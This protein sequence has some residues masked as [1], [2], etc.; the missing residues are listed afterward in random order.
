M[1]HGFMS[2]VITNKSK[3]HICRTKIIHG[4]FVNEK[5]SPIIVF[6]EMLQLKVTI[7]L[8]IIRPT[9]HGIKTIGDL[10]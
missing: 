9:L 10:I 3:V 2:I 1:I 5:S 7:Q 4:F 6:D 8:L